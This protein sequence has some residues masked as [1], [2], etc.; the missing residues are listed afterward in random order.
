MDAAFGW[1]EIDCQSRSRE[2]MAISRPD[3]LGDIAALGLTLAEASSCWCSR[4]GGRC[5]AGSPAHAVSAG[6]SVMQREWPR[7]GLATAPDC[8]AV[9]EVRVKLPRLALRAAVV[10]NPWRL[11]HRTGRSTLSWTK[12]QARLSALM[13]YRVAADVLQHLCRSTPGGAPRHCVAIATGRQAARRWRRREAAGRRRGHHDQFGFTFIRSREDGERH[14]EV[15]VGQRRERLMVAA[16]FLAPSPGP[17]RH[18]R[19]DQRPL[20]PWPTDTTK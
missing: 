4:A 10:A 11:A 5:G 17:R 19:V 8:D 9:R 12:L 15:R 3:G 18:Y 6:L 16:R 20:K 14:L 1:D 13:P 7:E 2:V